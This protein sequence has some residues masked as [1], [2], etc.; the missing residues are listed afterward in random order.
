[1]IKEEEIQG[2]FVSFCR[3]FFLFF[4]FFAKGLDKALFRCYD[5]FTVLA[6]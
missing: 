2:Y 3:N 1:M 5:C 4:S 6:D